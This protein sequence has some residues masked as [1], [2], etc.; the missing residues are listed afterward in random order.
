[1]LSIGIYIFFVL[2]FSFFLFLVVSVLGERDM[3][4]YD[5][6]TPFE[7]GYDNKDTGRLPFSIRFFLLAV[8]FLVFDIEVAL[9]FP[10]VIGV[11]VNLFSWVVVSGMGFLFI[12][13]L[14]LLHE[15]RTGALSW[16]S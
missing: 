2:F 15:W 10:L 4:D 11:G 5:K 8:I 16:V 9:L 14:G 3:M 6:F 7:C 12:L 13:V 1:M